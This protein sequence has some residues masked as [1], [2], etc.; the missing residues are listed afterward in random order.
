ME[1]QQA[2]LKCTLYSI[3]VGIHSVQPCDRAANIT[4]RN[5]TTKAQPATAIQPV[6]ASCTIRVAIKIIITKIT[7]ITIISGCVRKANSLLASSC[8][9]VR[10]HA[11]MPV[12][13]DG[14]SWNF[15]FRVLKKSVRLFRFRFKSDKSRMTLDININVHICGSLYKGDTALCDV[16]TETKE[17][18]DDLKTLPPS[19]RHIAYSKYKH[20][21]FYEIR[22]ITSYLAVY[23]RTT[24]NMQQIAVNGSS[25]IVPSGRRGKLKW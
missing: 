24:R 22:T 21:A 6:L 8:R 11:T 19:T 9:S 20:L 3:P 23:H 5:I 10:P 14:F 17:T 15:I 1:N 12:P 2:Y 13:P 16:S 4:F 18:T 7:T 25:K